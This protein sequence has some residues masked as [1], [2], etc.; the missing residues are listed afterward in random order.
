M[1]KKRM[2][3]LPCEVDEFYRIAEKLSSC[4]R[5]HRMKV[6]A[7]VSINKIISKTYFLII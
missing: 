2:K 1:K 7:E 3:T 4:F 5:L 6:V